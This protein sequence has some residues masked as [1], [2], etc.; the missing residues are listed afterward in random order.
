MKALN[1]PG[2]VFDIFFCHL[3]FLGGVLLVAVVVQPLMV[4]EFVACG[5]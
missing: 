5:A 2:R 1:C 4:F 3:L